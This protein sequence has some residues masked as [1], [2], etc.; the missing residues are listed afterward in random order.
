MTVLMWMLQTA[1]AAV[2]MLNVITNLL[3]KTHLDSS[4]AAEL[5]ESSTAS[6]SFVDMIVVS[7]G[8]FLRCDNTWWDTDEIDT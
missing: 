7:P 3:V 5:I 1:D 2:A 4:L 8:E 6:S